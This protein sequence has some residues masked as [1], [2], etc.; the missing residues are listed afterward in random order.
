MERRDFVGNS[1]GRS[2]LR[3]LGCR[4]VYNVKMELITIG[5]C[6]MD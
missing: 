5:C 1:E 3:R 4:W 6:S 2:L